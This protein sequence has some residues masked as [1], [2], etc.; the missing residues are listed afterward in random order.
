VEAERLQ[1]SSLNEFK[2]T[3]IWEYLII[4]L[5]AQWGVFEDLELEVMLCTR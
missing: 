1:R 4:T 5:R 2:F 3:D